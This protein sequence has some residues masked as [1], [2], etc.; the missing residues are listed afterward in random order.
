MGKKIRMK[1]T[2]LAVVLTAGLSGCIKYAAADRKK[3]RKDSSRECASAGKEREKCPGGFYAS[4]LKPA[5]DRLFSAAGLVALS[6]LYVCIGALIWLDDPGP[7]LFVQKR[8]GKDQQLFNLHKFRTMRLSAPHDVPTHRLEDPQRY[9]TGTGRIL[10][11]TSLDELPQLWDIFLGKMSFVGPRPA[12]WNQHDLVG[13]RETYGANSVRPGL[14][15]WAQINGR[16]ELS[17]SVKAALDG[18]YVMRLNQGGWKAML[19]DAVCLL[20][21]VMKVC[22]ADGVIEGASTGSS[23]MTGKQPVSSGG[24]AQAAQAGNPRILS[25]GNVQPAP[26]GKTQ[27]YGPAILVVCQYYYPENFQVTPVCEALAADG[28]RVTVLTGL[29]N[30]PSGTVPWEYRHGHRD[31]VIHG[32]RVVRCHEA[33]R[34]RGVLRLAWNYATFTASAV[35]RAGLLEDHYDLV[36]CYQLSPVFMGL[37]AVRYAGR[38]RVPFVLY[39]CDIWPESVRMYIHNV[40]GP[41]FWAVRSVSGRIYRAADHIVVQSA[42]FMDYLKKTHGIAESGMT[43]I[44]AFADDAYLTE[45]FTP[46][47]GTVDF[48][49]LGNLGI[50]QD[51]LSVLRAVRLIRHVPGFKVHF[52]GDGACLEA[53]KQYVWAEGLGHI[54]FFYGRRPAKEMPEYYRLADACLVSL[55]ADNATGYTLPS[56][57]QGY[58]AAGKPLIGMAD[59]DIRDVVEASGCGVCVRAGDVKALGLAMKDFIRNRWKYRDCGCKARTYFIEN[60]QKDSCIR[61]LEDVLEETLKQGV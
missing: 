12:L 33:G 39:C 34:K 32:V 2:V 7:V 52:V 37:P 36:L 13:E 35:H 28:Y 41:L 61:R 44:P 60:F 14:T 30:Y 58:M 40:H 24:D 16:D 51:L 11:R 25:G 22:R 17:I 59:G 6:P 47:D 18:E 26:E 19:S 21:T 10:R 4:R 50:A 9:I 5:A 3:K 45:N 56:K 27:P 23:S 15:G 20:G 38:H 53:M 55:K 49:F 1:I 31:E 46:E 48:V 42:S 43:H 29:P 54:V 57:V 8:V